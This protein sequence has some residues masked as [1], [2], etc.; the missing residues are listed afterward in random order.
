MDKPDCHSLLAEYVEHASEPAFRELVARYGQLVHRAALRQVNGDDALAQDIA[1]IVFTDLARLARGLSAEVLLG[2]WLHRRVCHVAAKLRRG[3]RRRMARE[4]EVVMQPEPEL[5]ELQLA[6]L[7]QCLDQAIDKLPQEDRAAIALRFFEDF[8]LRAIGTRLGISED[9]AQKR[10]SRSL[11][12]LQQILRKQGVV[13]PAG[14]L[15]AFLASE[16]VAG[17]TPVWLG[18]VAGVAL[19]KAAVSSGNFLTLIQILV[20]TKLKAVTIAVLATVMV[21]TTGW[22]YFRSQESVRAGVSN[23]PI[24]PGAMN[25]PE[26]AAKSVL[27]AMSEGNVEALHLCM[28]E[29]AWKLMEAEFVN[30]SAAEIST[31]LKTLAQDAKVTPTREKTL[32]N[33]HIVM[34][35]TSKRTASE[36]SMANSEMLMSFAKVGDVWK[37]TVD[38]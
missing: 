11:E 8:D 10:V 29:E 33:G 37:A 16:A 36:Q 35:L 21:A 18:A 20:M 14:V 17:A 24:A 34:A 26:A 23:S 6:Q 19:A 7:R 27:R 12:K 30:K 13:C 15:A 9:T 31:M 38:R 28:T 32:S 25:T 1:Q 3:E 5:S 4:K 22:V 2:G